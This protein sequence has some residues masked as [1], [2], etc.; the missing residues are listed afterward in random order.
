MYDDWLNQ[1]LPEYLLNDLKDIK[2]NEKE[3]TERFY[4]ALSFGTGGM[5]GIIGAGT[6]RMNI[7]TIRH[8]A[9]GLARYIIVNGEE[10][11]NRGV[12]LAYDTRHFSLEFACETARVLGA[13]GIRSYV[14]KLPR[15]TP[16]LS[17]T[18]RE[19][20][21]YAGVMITAS[22]NPKQY[23]GFKVY[24]EDGA[25]L[26]PQFAN[27]IVAK[28]YEVTD[29][30]SIKVKDIQELESN[31]RFIWLPSDFDE[32]YMERLLSLKSFPDES[33]DLKLVYTSLH[34]AGL[35]PIKTGF[36]RFGFN[37]VTIV[38]DQS[39]PDGDFP[40]A[41][42]PNPETSEAFEKAINI[43]KEVEAKILLAT[44]PDADRLGM[45]VW[46]G[47]SYELLTGNQIGALLIDYLLTSK[48]EQGTLPEN[49]I[50]IK[51]IVT[52]ELG[53]KIAKHHKIET[54]N[55]LTGFKYI[56]EKIAQ[57]ESSKS[58][59]YLFG[60]EE[61]YGYLIE[62]FA[63]DKDAVQVALKIAEVAAIYEKKGNTLLDRLEELHQQFGYHKELLLSE[64]FEGKDGQEKMMSLL[65]SIRENS[66]NDFLGIPVIRI[67]D[68]LLGKA[69][70]SSGL[71]KDITLPK[72]NVMKFILE[73]ET[74]I[75]IRPSGTEPKCKFYIGVV[76]KNKGRISDKLEKMRNAILQMISEKNNNLFTNG[77]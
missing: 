72:E 53:A 11:K 33:Y 68:Y 42:N 77:V 2:Q 35:E 41:P 59:E 58:F 34:G 70:L 62:P 30:F 37:N 18:V 24:G 43:G 52:S 23:N 12:I 25:Q 54:E 44:D 28:M 13:H 21:A 9:E 60:Y 36:E 67:E 6:N 49:G 7:Y 38:K 16:Q 69:T 71:K 27:E 56:A 29:L 75:T 61:S 32:V 40:L 74:W 26:T 1:D 3:I 17:F 64:T 57:Y 50:I 63:R 19:L 31:G 55:T 22:H 20:N 76:G 14:Y 73:D 51:T 66:P 65:E 48:K 15:P 45:A 47:V 46:N 10:A 5:R 39:V 8:V 4:Q